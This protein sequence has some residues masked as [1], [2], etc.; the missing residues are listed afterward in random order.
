MLV[1][2]LGEARE[3]LVDERERIRMLAAIAAGEPRELEV[4]P[5]GERGSDHAT[6]RHDRQPA[7][8]HLVRARR[9]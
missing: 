3:D 4:L 5:D 7:V 9:Q 2:P 6:L 1:T 8:H